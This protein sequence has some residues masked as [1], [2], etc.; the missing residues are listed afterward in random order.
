MLQCG[1]VLWVC[2]WSVLVCCPHA[3]AHTEWFESANCDQRAAISILVTATGNIFIAV[4]PWERHLT[5]SCSPRSNIAVYYSCVRLKTERF[6]VVDVSSK[7]KCQFGELC[8]TLLTDPLTLKWKARLVNNE[9]NHSH[10]LSDIATK[11]TPDFISCNSS[12]PAEWN[13]PRSHHIDVG[14]GT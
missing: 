3:I 1:L 6:C 13:I 14:M 8:N 7:N 2:L 11:Q 10:Q 12:P 5:P 4:C 9:N